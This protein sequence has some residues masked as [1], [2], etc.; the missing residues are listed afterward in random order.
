MYLGID[1]CYSGFGKQIVFSHTFA[2]GF[3]FSTTVTVC[4]KDCELHTQK[5][6]FESFISIF[7]WLAWFFTGRKKIKAQSLKKTAWAY[8]WVGVNTSMCM[9]VHKRLRLGLRIWGPQS[10]SQNKHFCSH[11]LL[12][13][14]SQTW[15]NHHLFELYLDLWNLSD[16]FKTVFTN[17][18]GLW[19][20]YKA[21]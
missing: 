10:L 20:T 8:A 15:A 9:W 11:A 12:L 18:F 7:S 17:F 3:A 14:Y 4:V 13:L 5:Y 16:H 19:H 2:N 1:K 6:S 21:Q